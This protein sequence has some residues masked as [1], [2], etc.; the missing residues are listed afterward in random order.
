MVSDDN[1]VNGRHDFLFWY[2]EGNSH[3]NTQKENNTTDSLLKC[4]KECSDTLSRSLVG[5]SMGIELPSGTFDW[6]FTSQPVLSEENVGEW[7][8]V[9]ERTY[10][11]GIS[12][13]GRAVAANAD[14]TGIEGSERPRPDGLIQLRDRNHPDTDPY[15][16][17]LEVKTGDD[18]LSTE[19]MA[20]YRAAVGLTAPEHSDQ[21]QEIDW[22]SVYGVFT[23]HLERTDRQPDRFLIDE[24][25]EYLSWF[26]LDRTIATHP[27]SYPKFMKLSGSPQEGR[28]KIEVKFT[29]ERDDGTN[30]QSPSF[31]AAEL[32]TCLDQIPQEIRKDAF[33]GADL[34]VLEGWAR[35]KYGDGAIDDGQ[36]IAVSPA[37]EDGAT[38]VVNQSNDIAK[39]RMETTENVVESIDVRH[40]ALYM[41]GSNLL[42]IWA[43][44]NGRKNTHIP[45]VLDPEAFETLME[46]L[47]RA[48]RYEAFGMESPDIGALWE[49]AL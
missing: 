30:S 1:F 6:E 5:E 46:E 11:V 2:E 34:S 31:T 29:W 15:T 18:T 26:E 3:S 17:V 8:I 9:P 21:C 13:K 44:D 35:S 10:L 45:A 16:I 4:L 47:D 7:S 12:K 49:G 20:K 28:N 38:V 27:G 36:R 48:T 22:L 37:E 23:D 39:I 43:G 33:V 41:D 40:K 25:K 14:P 24:F 32:N 42:P 19:E